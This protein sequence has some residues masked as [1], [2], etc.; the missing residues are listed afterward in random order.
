MKNGVNIY[1]FDGTIYDGDSSIDFYLFCLRKNVSIIKFLPVFIIGLL[2]LF[3]S[4]NNF[5]LLFISLYLILSLFL[6]DKKYL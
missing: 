5:S 4:K 3:Q 6:R 2:V 1:D